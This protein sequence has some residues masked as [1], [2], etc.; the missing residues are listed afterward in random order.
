MV[1]P[2]F[3]YPSIQE[4][5][6]S[7]INIFCK[8]TGC[9]DDT[10]LELI[11]DENKFSSKDDMQ[12]W[13]NVIISKMEKLLLP[14]DKKYV[15]EISSMDLK[16]QQ[17]L[18][19]ARTYLFYQ[20]LIFATATFKLQ[21]LYDNVYSDQNLFPY[22]VDLSTDEEL[23][24][25]KMGIFGTMSPTSDIDIGIQY[26][27]YTLKVPGL[28]YIV[29]RFEN[30]FIIFTGKAS[31]DYDIETYADMMTIPSPPDSSDEWKNQDFFY[32]DSGKF[33]ENEYTR[34]LPIAY[35]SILR[36]F[37]LTLIPLKSENEVIDYT[38]L[39]QITLQE[40]TSYFISS[41]ELKSKIINNE[42]FEESKKTISTFFTLTYDQQ[43]YEYYKKVDAAEKLKFSY[44]EKIYSL[45][46]DQICN[47]MI[48]IGDALTYRME[49]Y[50]CAPT[51]IHVV[52]SMQASSDKYINTIPN[53]VENPKFKPLCVIGMYGYLLSILEQIGYM[54]RFHL[55][56]CIQGMD[57]YDKTKCYKKQEK[58]KKRL[59]DAT[60]KYTSVQKADMDTT[61]NDY[62]KINEK[63]VVSPAPPIPQSFNGGKRR[64]TK[65]YSKKSRAR[66]SQRKL[67]SQRRI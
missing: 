8:N 46:P 19:I 35:N 63:D 64:N 34:M 47:L 33:T 43:R 23:T 55:T 49:S 14:R 58:Y 41:D 1:Y 37:Y 40:I 20:L 7:D 66:K 25:F 57:H 32:L 54:Y 27:G 59:E 31:L 38:E 52:R 56:Y 62:N 50:T 22:R 5:C 44:K 4:R 6:L 30:L 53:C 13:I 45:E 10:E 15:E 42:K 39:P 67:R 24:N 29:S 17:Q 60:N 9:K 26:S 61:A 12:K 18:W 3:T 51:V 11:I 48:L 2:V 28:A 16:I 65:K 36:N 21:N